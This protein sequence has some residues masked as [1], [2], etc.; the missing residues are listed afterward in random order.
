MSITRLRPLA[1]RGYLGPARLRAHDENERTLERA[2]VAEHKYASTAE[3]AA[4]NHATPRVAV[5]VSSASVG[6][7]G[8]SITMLTTDDARRVILAAC[9]TSDVASKPHVV[10]INSL[11]ANGTLLVSSLTSALGSGNTWAAV[12][13]TVGFAEFSAASSSDGTMRRTD[14][15]ISR[16]PLKW[17]QANRLIR[18]QRYLMHALE[19]EHDTSGGHVIAG[20]AAFVGRVDVSGTTYTANRIGGSTGCVISSPSRISEGIYEATFNNLPRTTS[21]IPTLGLSVQSTR[22]VVVNCYHTDSDT[23]RFYGYRLE[24]GSWYRRDIPFFFAIYR[25]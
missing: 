11:K 22:P 1:I 15:T 20:V 25:S 14:D 6:T 8:A 10:S 17:S 12:S 9:N 21:L 13:R 19:N 23:V 2:F 18:N 7:G 5:Q 16:G 3:Y 24:S 4:A